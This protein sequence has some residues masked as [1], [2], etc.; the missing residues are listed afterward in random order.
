[1]PVNPDPAD[2]LNLSLGGPILCSDV[3]SL[4]DAF[5]Q[6]NAAGAAVVVAAGN[7]GADASSFTPASCGGVIAV[8]ATTLADTR[9][10][11]SNYGA[12]IDVRAPGGLIA[13]DGDG[14]GYPDGVLSTVQNPAGEADYAYFEGTSMASPHVAG[15]VALM[16]SVRPT[17]SGAEARDILKST[18]RP[19]TDPLCSVGCGSGLI[20]AA[21]ALAALSAPAAPDFALSLSPATVSL[22]AGASG[23][24]EVRVSRSGG[25]SSEVAFSVS[26]LPSGLSASFTP[27]VTSGDSTRLTLSATAGLTGEYTLQVQGVGDGISKTVPLSVVIEGDEPTEPVADIAGTVVLACY[28]VNDICDP[29]LSRA[30]D[31]T[32]SGSSAPYTITNLSAINYIVG[33]VKD[34]NGDEDY[35]DAEDYIGFYL[36]NGQPAAVTP[37]VTGIDV[38]MTPTLSTQEQQALLK[39]LEGIR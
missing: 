9:A 36:Q 25:F 18:A 21:A 2:V 1:M 34:G 14:N 35:L 17:L 24:T 22:A 32:Q 19:I 38:A 23:S 28:Y 15:V 33:A 8:G 31:I 12:R 20:D 3:P 6:A 37:P 10:S 26:G 39:S 5:D 27:S 11:Y 30:V 16:K 4:Q 29:S 13:E 7:E